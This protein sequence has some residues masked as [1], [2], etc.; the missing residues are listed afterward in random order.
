M[1]EKSRWSQIWPLQ[2]A[3]GLRNFLLIFTSQTLLKQILIKKYQGD[4][5][6]RN[7]T[8]N[9]SRSPITKRVEL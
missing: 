7:F 9:F 4:S 6:K 3:M 8:A 2:A 1:S 5:I